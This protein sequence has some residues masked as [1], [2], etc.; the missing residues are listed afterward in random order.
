MKK[1]LF[2]VLACGL[3]G[4]GGSQHD[5]LR[6]KPIAFNNIG[7]HEAYTFEDR[8]C[9]FVVAAVGGLLHHPMCENQHHNCDTL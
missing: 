2:L 7:D 6:I 1:T 8:G 3:F 4:C 9:L 5:G